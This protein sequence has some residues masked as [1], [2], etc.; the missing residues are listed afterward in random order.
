MRTLELTS[1]NSVALEVLSKTSSE[2]LDPNDPHMGA[3]ERKNKIILSNLQYWAMFSIAVLCTSSL[4][5]L[6]YLQQL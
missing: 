1:G 2:F 6:I 4:K 3:G 5:S